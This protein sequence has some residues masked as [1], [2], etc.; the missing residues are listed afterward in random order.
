MATVAEWGR[1]PVAVGSAGRS[2]STL[3]APGEPAAEH[4]NSRSE[5]NSWGEEF[6]HATADTNDTP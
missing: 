6:G 4:T 2:R 5:S 1:L 3:A